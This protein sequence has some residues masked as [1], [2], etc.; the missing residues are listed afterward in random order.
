M[1]SNGHRIVLKTVT[2]DG[3][4]TTALILIHGAVENACAS[5]ILTITNSAS[6]VAMT[7]HLHFTVEFKYLLALSVGQNECTL[8][9]CDTSIRLN[10]VYEPSPL[11]YSVIPLY[12]V[13][14]GHDGHFQS[15][16]GLSALSSALVACRRI[17]V[18]LQLVQLVYAEKLA[19]AGLGRRSFKIGGKCRAYLSD[20]GVEKA[21]QMTEQELWD[22]LADEIIRTEGVQSVQRKKYVAIV[23]CTR[24]IGASDG[25]NSYETIK[26]RT[27]ARAAI[28][29]GGLVV[30]NTGCLYTWPDTVDEVVEVLRN[31]QP[32]DMA[33]FADDSNYRRTIGGCFATNIGSLCHELG[34]VFDL[35]HTEE[36]IMGRSF[37][38]TERLFLPVSSGSENKKKFVLPK[39]SSPGKDRTMPGLTGLTRVRVNGSVLRDY[40]KERECNG[41]YFARN[42]LT[43][44]GHHKW[45]Q[46]SGPEPQYENNNN[47]KSLSTNPCQ[48]TMTDKGGAA[49]TAVCVDSGAMEIKAGKTEKP[50]LRFSAT[51]RVVRAEYALRLVELRELGSEMVK[52]YWEL[53][54]DEEDSGGEGKTEFKLAPLTEQATNNSNSNHRS[55]PWILFAIDCRGNTLKCRI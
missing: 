49:A 18:M 9:Y 14:K 42:C 37:D 51:E 53:K 21:L 26:K 8:S 19:E 11:G 32:V 2:S 31:D 1:C 3:P 24:F 30:F 5:D 4:I 27:L 36:G 33:R 40:L 28:G 12:I 48:T 23:G 39:R 50:L 43:I 54:E 38:G 55:R 20:L 52:Q 10:L 35:G 6:G 44:L 7:H 47:D 25:D 45:F 46:G 17:D 34:H 22:H 15:P 41:I 29:G 16:V 13:C